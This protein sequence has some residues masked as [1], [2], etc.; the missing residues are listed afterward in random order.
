M[1]YAALQNADPPVSLEV[2]KKSFDARGQGR[3]FWWGRGKEA[4]QSARV[5]VVLNYMEGTDLC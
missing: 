4:M 3:S 1:R 5:F 2:G